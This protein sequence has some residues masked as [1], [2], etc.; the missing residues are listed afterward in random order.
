[1]TSSEPSESAADTPLELP[2]ATVPDFTELDNPI[3][4]ALLTGHA[5]LALG[6]GL[7]RRYPAAIGPLSGIP[8]QSA[9]SYAALRGLAGPGGVVVL[10]LREPPAPPAGWTLVLGGHVDQMVCLESPGSEPEYSNADRAIE[11][12][13]ASDV[14][15]MI[16]L[17]RLTEPGP[18]NERTIELGQFFGIFGA[19]RLLAMAGQRMHFDRFVE[20]SAVCT[21]PDARGRG[22][23]RALTARAADQVRKMGKIPILHVFSHNRAAIR[24]YES[25]G[26]VRRRTFELAVLKN[27]G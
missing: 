18:F 7:A 21:H 3:W 10:F 27:D 23:A 25:L 14:P 20:V 2:A 12:L 22:Y 13:T 8:S 16:E 1:M 19:G 6:G 11:R 5:S 26:F 9:A 24:V 17:A 15:A 4:Y